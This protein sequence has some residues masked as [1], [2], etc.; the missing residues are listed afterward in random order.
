MKKVLFVIVAVVLLAS[1]IAISSARERHQAGKMDHKWKM[2][3]M[4]PVHRM[5]AQSM[6]ARSITATED[7]GVVVLAGNMLMKFD[8]NLNFVKEV[9][10]K[11]DTEAIQKDIKEMMEKCPM[12]KA[13]IKEMEEM[14]E[15]PHP[16]AE[17][18]KGEL[19]TMQEGVIEKGKEKIRKKGYLD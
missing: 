11:I 15:H 18:T 13:M 6:F 5:T 12:R 8:E 17:D 4:C 9:Q 3:P 10:I 2:A 19:D 14:K 16:A 7:G 1:I